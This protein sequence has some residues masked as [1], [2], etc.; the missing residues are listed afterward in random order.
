MG[1]RERQLRLSARLQ[2][3]PAPPP[4]RVSPPGRGQSMASSEEDGAGGGSLEEKE[5]GR[6][7]RLGALATAWLIGYNIA[8]TAGWL[9]LAIAM[10]RFYMQKGTYK[11]LYKTI[12][13]TL[14]FFQTFA[15]LEKNSDLD[16]MLHVKLR[17]GFEAEEQGSPLCSWNS[18]HLCACDWGPSE[19]KNLHGL[20]YNTQYKTEIPGDFQPS[21]TE[22][23]YQIP[24]LL[25]K[26]I[27][28][29][30]C[31]SLYQKVLFVKDPQPS[32]L[33]SW[34][35][36]SPKDLIFEAAGRYAEEAV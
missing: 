35:F 4:P 21:G 17:F 31:N 30:V 6:K 29:L 33:H 12:Q 34:G 7:R 2:P 16:K 28:S 10:A 15:V 14:K 18:S 11:G 36:P 26:I 19:F 9:V 32:S 22:A 13:K 27:K 25:K 8:L 24:P 5:K 1:V 3:G 20:V 23:Y